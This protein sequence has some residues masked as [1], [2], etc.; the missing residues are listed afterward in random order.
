MPKSILP[1]ITLSYC[2]YNYSIIQFICTVPVFSRTVLLEF[3]SQLFCKPQSIFRK[4]S[5]NVW[6]SLAL[7]VLAN[8]RRCIHATVCKNLNVL[9]AV[10]AATADLTS[11][12]S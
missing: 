8:R 10:L 1:L 2:S 3:Y 9:A 4:P 5:T 6:K 12:A 7:P 11:R